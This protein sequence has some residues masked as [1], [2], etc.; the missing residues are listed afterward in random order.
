MQGP[1][2]GAAL[3]ARHA[4][5]QAVSR[6]AT[7][8]EAPTQAPPCVRAALAQTQTAAAPLRPRAPKAEEATA[9][10]S[11]GGGAYPDCGMRPVWGPARPSRRTPTLLCGYEGKD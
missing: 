8:G 9:K 10:D 3:S 6:E 2:R 5:A 4:Q 1:L 7:G 11:C